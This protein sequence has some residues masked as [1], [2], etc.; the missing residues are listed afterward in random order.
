MHWSSLQILNLANNRFFGRIP[1]FVGILS[2]IETFDLQ[3]NSFSGEIPSSLKNC[4]GLQF[5]GLSNTSLSGIIPNWIGESLISLNFLHLKSNHFVGGIPWELCQLPN[6][7]LLDLFDSNLSGHRPWCIC[8]PTTLARKAIS[9]KHHFFNC[10]LVSNGY[11]DYEG[12]YVDEASFI[13]RGKE[14]HYENLTSKD[15]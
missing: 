3:N 2:W 4:S 11:Y 7:L 13:W 9:A 15:H 12:S 8:N 14:Y 10:S 1:N 5:L 6:I